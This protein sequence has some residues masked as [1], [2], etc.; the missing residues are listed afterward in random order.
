ME[1]IRYNG[2]RISV[3]TTNP[4]NASKEKVDRKGNKERL[5]SGFLLMVKMMMLMKSQGLKLLIE[6]IF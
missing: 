2:E 3:P 6:R 5:T 1:G 4:F